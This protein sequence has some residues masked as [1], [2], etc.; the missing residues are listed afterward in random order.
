MIKYYFT[1]LINLIIS[2]SYSQSDIAALV[3]PEM[4]FKGTPLKVRIGD[5]INITQLNGIN[6]SVEILLPC[7]I[8]L[9]QGENFS[10]TY[11]YISSTISEIA[12][13]YSDLGFSC[14]PEAS[15]PNNQ[16]DKVGSVRCV[17]SSEIPQPSRWVG[18]DADSHWTS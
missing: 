18:A 2:I 14:I 6:K 9:Y 10:G 12:K 4:N 7:G 3:Y 16:Y 15:R 17:G 8:Y 13:P 1:I 11:I 5:E